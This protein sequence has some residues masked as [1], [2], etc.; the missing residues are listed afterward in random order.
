MCVFGQTNAWR[1]VLK[2][3]K[4]IRENVNP[5]SYKTRTYPLAFSEEV[6]FP[7]ASVAD[8][9]TRLHETVV[10]LRG[11]AVAGKLEGHHGGH[12]KSDN[13]RRKYYTNCPLPA[14][15]AKRDLSKHGE[16]GFLRS[17]TGTARNSTLTSP[18]RNRIQESSPTCSAVRSRASDSPG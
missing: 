3:F 17:L 13:A 9:G 1:S 12:R 11:S 10:A 6:K 16:N 5:L 7:Q 15:K 8:G 4:Y 14:C 2:G 18:R